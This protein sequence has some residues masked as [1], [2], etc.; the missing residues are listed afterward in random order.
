[1]INRVFVSGYIA[2]S[3]MLHRHPRKEYRFR[4]YIRG[5]KDSMG[6]DSCYLANICV[7]NSQAMRYFPGNLERGDFVVIEGELLSIRGSDRNWQTV[8]SAYCVYNLA[9]F[10]E[11]NIGDARVRRQEQL[12]ELYQ[13]LLSEENKRG[14]DGLDIF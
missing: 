13:S 10:L 6:D 5:K 1:M 11:S 2:S 7:L 14:P 9:V 3:I 12:A 4:L 8:V